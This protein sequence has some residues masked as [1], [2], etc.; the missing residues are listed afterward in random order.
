M[1]TAKRTT[2]TWEDCDAYSHGSEI[3]LS[4]LMA[5]GYESI[6]EILCDP[7]VARR[8]DELAAQFAPGHSPFE[9]RWAAL[10]LRKEAK[11]ARTRA[12]LL[13]PGRFSGP[14][15]IGTPDWDA[16]PA[17]AGIYIVRQAGES[18][19]LYVGESFNLRSRLQRQFDVEGGAAVAWRNIA[20]LEQLEVR[21]FA[22]D[23]RPPELLAYQSLV[24]HK[25]QSRLNY[26]ELMHA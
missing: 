17:A 3:A 15:S 12:T 6:D 7:R 19:A 21:V 2:V 26:P 24:A 5:E 4:L 14:V 13:S 22:A 18:Q 16:I 1:A 9:Y 10:K 20:P 25:H 23:P 8:F 11:L